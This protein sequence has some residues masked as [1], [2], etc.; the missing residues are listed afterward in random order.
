[1]LVSYLWGVTILGDVPS[2]LG[3]SVGSV[4]VIVSGVVVIAFSETLA[5][6]LRSFSA[7]ASTTASMHTSLLRSDGGGKT[8]SKHLIDN[9]DQHNNFLDHDY[10]NS[11]GNDNNRNRWL[12]MMMAFCVGLFGG[13]ILAPLN[14]VPK[15]QTGLV[16]V[17]SF[18]MGSFAMA[19]L[20]LATALYRSRRV[21]EEVEFNCM[22]GLPLGILSGTMYQLSNILSII[23]IP[24][25]GYGVAYPLLQCAILFSGIWGVLV[26]KEITGVTTIC[27][28]FMGGA[29]LLTGA[30]MLA[31]AQ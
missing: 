13:S 14:Y 31:V 20:V 6:K 3:L 30:A 28:F 8:D 22:Y 11:I 9:L 24:A 5:T 23:A 10:D 29:I 27:I 15:E 26:F 16:F 19:T 1:M 4:V 7:I 17:P 12:G 25:L 18:G 2:S 21:G